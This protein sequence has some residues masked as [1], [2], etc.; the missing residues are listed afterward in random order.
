LEVP[1]GFRSAIIGNFETTGQHFF[2]I[3]I[4]KM[5]SSVA[6]LSKRIA[7]VVA[8]QAKPPARTFVKPTMPA[9]GGQH[10]VFEPNS[11]AVREN[12]SSPGTNKQAIF[13]FGAA[14]LGREI[15][16]RASV[17]VC[18]ILTS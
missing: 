9:K 2:R 14:P 18:Q 16:A 15:A 1:F 4:N 3:G 5:S 12:P 10:Y 11:G 7:P 17:F 13:F 6:L 8:R